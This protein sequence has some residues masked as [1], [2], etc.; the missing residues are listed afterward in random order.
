MN[1]PIFYPQLTYSYT[2]NLKQESIWKTLSEYSVL[3]AVQDW[4]HSLSHITNKSY[5]C[6][7]NQLIRLGILDIDQNLQAFS[8][9]C[10]NVIID[11]IKKV[12]HW[13]EASRQARAAC[14]IS[15]T[16]YLSRKTDGLIKRAIPSKEGTDR[17]F[18]R[19]REKVSTQAM[20]RTQWTAFL[21]ELSNLNPRDCLIAKIALQGG[22]RIN[23]VLSLQTNE[24]DFNTREITF[25]QSKTKGYEKETVITYPHLIMKELY[26][27]LQGRTGIVFITSNENPVHSTQ[28]TNTFEKAGMRAEV[29]FK[30]TPQVLRA[31]AVTYLKKEG[32]SDCQ[33]MKITGHASSGMVNAYDKSSRADNISK[34]VSL[35]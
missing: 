30:V 24:I 14:Y 32:F 6:S 4:L 20:T 22:K 29:P 17:T 1:L 16:R 5:Q 12:S 26:H 11:K 27:Y 18:F 19:I 28:L 3:T 15:F 13:S 23:E 8:M 34:K 21:Y 35:V 10:H 31:S 7:I 2:V 25:K 33:I 9:I